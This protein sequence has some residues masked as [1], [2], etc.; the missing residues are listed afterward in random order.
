MILLKIET[1]SYLAMDSPAAS[2][3]WVQVNFMQSEEV[4]VSWEFKSLV[5]ES[6]SN[7]DDC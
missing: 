4:L 2:C 1:T 3:G 5:K 7:N 6:S